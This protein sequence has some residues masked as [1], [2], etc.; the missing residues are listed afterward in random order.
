MGEQTAIQWTTHTLNFWHGCRKVSAGCRFCYMYRDKERYG[1]DPAVVVRS[2]PQTFNAAVATHGRDKVDVETGTLA[3]KG[4]WKWP[5]GGRVF[6]CSWSDFFIEEADAWRADA[7]DVIR[8]RP[9]LTWQILTKRPE[10]IRDRLPPD[11]GGG[12]GYPNV[13]LGISVEDQKAADARIPLLTEIPA[14]V[15]FL[16]IEPLLGP[17]DLSAWFSA[18]KPGM[19]WRE[20]DCAAI[21][22]SD[23]PCLSCEARC[24]GIGWV[25][26][27]G[28]S[29]SAT[30]SRDCRY[31]WIRDVVVASRRAGVPCFVKQLGSRY[32]DEP[33][34]LA[35]ARLPLAP[36]VRVEGAYT[37]GVMTTV[38]RLRHDHGG[39]MAEWPAQLRVR[40]FPGSGGAP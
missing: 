9:G 31:E 26:V 5:D 29:G 21:D 15:R 18:P 17:V 32:L 22:P 35:G 37:S 16:S 25:I 34:R 4:S 3:P 33:N 6:T 2:S 10:L 19:V 14:A 7:W 11:W 24:S 28:E 12:G 20:C 30:T 39:D 13:W 23:R 36:D 8:R 1:Q 40:Q 38:R 27:G